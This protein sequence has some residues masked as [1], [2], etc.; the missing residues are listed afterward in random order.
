MTGYTYDYVAPDNLVSPQAT[1]R[2]KALAPDGPNYKALV[3]RRPNI[4]YLLSILFGKMWRHEWSSLRKKDYPWYL[5][6]AS[7]R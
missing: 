4:I 5:L 2:A 1:V 6:A 3:L 7:R